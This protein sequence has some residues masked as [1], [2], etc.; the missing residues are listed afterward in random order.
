MNIFTHRFPPSCA[1]P[2][3]SDNAKG[4]LPQLTAW[5]EGVNTPDLFVLGT[6]AHSRDYRLSAGGF[7]HGFRYTGEAPPVTPPPLCVKVRNCLTDAGRETHSGLYLTCGVACCLAGCV[8]ARAV[9]RVLEQ[10]YHGNKWH[11]TELLTTQL[12]SWALKR[13]NEASG[14]YQM[15]G[16]LGDVILLRG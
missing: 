6:A 5:Y 12:M 2:P 7:V 11:S 4:R 16:V 13:I 15:V 1:R 14:I 9:H 3:N 10:R 8:A